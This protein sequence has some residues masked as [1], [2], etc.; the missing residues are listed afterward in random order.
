MKKIVLSILCMFLFSSGFAQNTD[1]EIKEIQSYIQSTSQNEWFDPINST[2]T[3]PSG[4]TYDLS[5]YLLPDSNIFSIIYT[6]FEKYTLQ[7]VFYY[8]N[9]QLIAC[10]VE[11]T[12]ANNANKLLR[13]ADYFYNNQQ[14]INTADE[15]KEIPS[16]SLH[17]EGLQ[18][19]N[20][21]VLNKK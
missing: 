12:D 14:L 16:A 8:K 1:A 19:L 13:Y 17:A 18:K 6:V 4:G 3:L 2:G 10:I 21:A 15:N 7:K 5:Y 20:E 9:N 11:E